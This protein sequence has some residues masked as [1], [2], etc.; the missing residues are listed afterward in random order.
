MAEAVDGSSRSG[1][2]RRR[3]RDFDDGFRNVGENALPILEP[4]AFRA[5]VFAP[6]E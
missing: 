6:R 1:P 5:T 2:R 3:S 4:L